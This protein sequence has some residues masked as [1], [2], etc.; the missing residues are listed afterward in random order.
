MTFHF[1]HLRRV[2]EIKVSTSLKP[3]IKSITVSVSIVERVPIMERF[4]TYEMYVKCIRAY[5]IESNSTKFYKILENSKNS[6]KVFVEFLE[7]FRIL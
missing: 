3:K 7:F 4:F 5:F 2:V 1:H 6:I